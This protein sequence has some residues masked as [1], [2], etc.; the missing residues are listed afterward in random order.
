M[1]GSPPF[2]KTETTKLLLDDLIRGVMPAVI[3]CLAHEADVSV[4]QELNYFAF[5]FPLRCTQGFP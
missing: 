4:Y 2:V 5:F 1:D 3:T